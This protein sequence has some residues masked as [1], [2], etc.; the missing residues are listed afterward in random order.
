MTPTRAEGEFMGHLLSE[1]A[2]ATRLYELRKASGL[3]QLQLAQAA[4]VTQASVSNYELGKRVPSQ[5]TLAAF[6]R[7]LQVSPSVLLD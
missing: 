3:T 7:C 2:S 1:R 5:R 6:A 4:R